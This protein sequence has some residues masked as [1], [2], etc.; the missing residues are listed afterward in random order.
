MTSAIAI[1][2]LGFFLGMRHA[3][4]ADHVIAVTTIVAR[5]RSVRSAAWIGAVWGIG[6]TVTILVV[7]GAIILFSWVI[8][9]RIGLS[10]ELAVG[11]MLVALGLMNLGGFWQRVQQVQP[12]AG[13]PLHGHAA[14]HPPAQAQLRQAA[15]QP[16]H[17]HPHEI[18]HVHAHAHRHGD[19]IHTHAHEHDPE[20]HPH[21]PDRTPLSRLDQRLGSL[22]LY[23]LVRPLVV[24]VVHGL[25]GSAAIALLVLTTIR[26]TTWGVVYLLIFGI[27]TI[28]GMM[29][30]TAAVSVPFAMT[31]AQF[32]RLNRQLRIVSGVVSL[33]FGLFIAWRIGIVGGLFTGHPQWT[34]R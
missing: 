12:A 13:A 26:S 7:G 4:D 22:R 21:D 11:L 25:A 1:A 34:P 9:P 30:V 3:T 8:P 20:R 31:G 2:T 29:L 33:A 10:M 23:Q 6:H 32:G 16:A 24:G 19:Y 17:A 28:A 15:D 18:P 27:G 5:H 14:T